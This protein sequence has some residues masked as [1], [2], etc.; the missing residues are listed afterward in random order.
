[1]KLKVQTNPKK[2]FTICNVLQVL[3]EPQLNKE[4]LEEDS[5]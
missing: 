3:L 2:I 1:M 5:Q 4:T